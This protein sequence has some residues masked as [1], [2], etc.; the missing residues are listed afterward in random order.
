MS[1]VIMVNRGAGPRDRIAF[2]I[3]KGEKAVFRVVLR[4]L[5]GRGNQ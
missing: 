3:Q 2:C 1:W 5:L 4:D